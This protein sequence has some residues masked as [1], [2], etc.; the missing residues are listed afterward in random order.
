[1]E[2]SF[3]FVIVGAGS[4]GCVLANR[5]SRNSGRK[6]LLLEAGG[7]DWNPLIAIPLGARKM[8]QW[9]LHDWGDMSEPDEN[10]DG[11]RHPVLHGKVVGGTSSINYM[12]HTRGHPNDYDR[13]AAAGAAGWSHAEVLPFFKQCE[14][15]AGGADERRG[16]AGELGAACAPLTDPLH[17]AWIAMA[18][19]Q[20]YAQ[21]ADIN[22][23]NCEG[24]APLQFT[25]RG[26]RRSSTARAF[27]R[28]A[29]RRPNLTVRTRAFATKILFEGKR[30]AGVEY[31]RKGRREIARCHGRVILCLG[32]INTPHLL[33]LSGVG[34]ADHLR[35]MGIAP[36]ADLPVGE[37]L[38]DHL[39]FGLS[40]AR[41]APGPF[42]AQL[43]LDRIGLSMIRAYLFGTGPASSP[44]GTLS[45]FIRSRPDLAQPDLEFLLSVVPGA[46]DFWLPGIKRAYRDA[47]AIRVYLLNQQ[48]RGKILL[49]SADPRDR[50]RIF[51][52][53]LSAPEDL[54]TLRAAFRRMWAMGSAPELSLFS[55]E[56]LVP[57]RALDSDE[58]VD[59]FIRREA[60]PQYHPACTCPMGNDARAVTTPNLD[61]RGLDG[62]SIADA[63]V[64]PR[65]VSAN[66]N[67]AVVMIAAKAA[68][69]W[70]G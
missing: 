58:E 50:P 44:P 33:M 42:H 14:T 55:A 16:G 70:T 47:F 24:L 9:N 54:A 2:T 61:V 46:A 19:R 63:S 15:W 11:R 27:L 41:P 65:L 4:A 38:E 40:W 26:G 23:E 51:F 21:S 49:R 13:W 5:L 7:W 20:G 39:G 10:L 12:A 57:P 30:A 37:N 69:I 60:M 25:V 35:E 43:R 18:R 8:T 32:A 45:A 1:M 31:L 62:L 17:D 29:L 67:I 34:P 48:S 66:P 68:E 3:D 53:S 6:V 64:M 56:A 52:N 28:P 59:A 36:I 22:G